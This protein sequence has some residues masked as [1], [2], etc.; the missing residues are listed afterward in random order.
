LSRGFVESQGN[1]G[2]KANRSQQFNTDAV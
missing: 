2:L 1:G